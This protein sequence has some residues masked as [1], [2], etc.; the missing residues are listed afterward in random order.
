MASKN[1]VEIIIK[2]TDKASKEV[3][4]LNSV[5][6][7]LGKVAAI[8][9]AA[10]VATGVVIGKVAFNLA[11]ESARVERLKNTFDSLA[12]SIGETSDVMIKDLRVAS[13]GMINDA[14]LMQYSGKLMA[15]GLADTS[16]E[17]GRLIEMATQLGSAMGMDATAS[18][19]QFALMLANQ[20]IR[21]L[22]EFGISSGTV[23]KRLQELMEADKNLTRETAFMMAVMEQGNATM[24][25]VGEQG[26]GAAAGMARLTAN[27]DN[28]KVEIGNRLRPVLETITTKLLEA[29]DNPEVQAG[30]E[31]LFIWLENVIGDEGSGVVGIITKLAEGD[32]KGAF[33]LAFGEEVAEW[34]ERIGE[35]LKAIGENLDSITGKAPGTT[36]VL[37]IMAGAARI[38]GVALESVL[39]VLEGITSL[40]SAVTKGTSIQPI[41]DKAAEF[42][43]RT[44]PGLTPNISNISTGRGWGRASGGPVSAGGSYL[45]GER[46]PEMLTMGGSSGY[47]TPNNK[48]GGATIV[49][50]LNSV[51]SL[52]DMENAKRVLQ[53][54]VES[55]L[56]TV[57]AR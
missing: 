41:Q 14:D 11:K 34:V 32:I 4:G 24:E 43:N 12:K 10:V 55:G 44:F 45:V 37:G 1:V 29:W 22:D 57:M 6:G 47:I 49:F 50:N 30:I 26:E 54:I 56:R 48:L 20:A 23:T 17:A 15:M 36:S 5:I 51:V 53:P 3:K 31:R 21:R 25:K 42:I 19:E 2:A 46:G 52:A 33:E 39:L 13:R 18:I 16:D 35:D 27:V 8:A 28:L 38:L 9:G 40:L 7:K